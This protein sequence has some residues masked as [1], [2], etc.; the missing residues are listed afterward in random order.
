MS[1]VS[2]LFVE[3]DELVRVGL[4]ML[5][6][7]MTG[8]AQVTLAPGGREALELIPTVHPHVVITDLLMPVFD[9]IA[10]TTI[11]REQHPGIPI[12]ILTAH[13]DEIWLSR[14][15]RA[16]VSGF[17]LK[18]SGVHELEVA[19]GAVTR[20]ERYVTPRMD[21]HIL[22]ERCNGAQSITRRQRETLQ[23]IANGKTNKEIAVSLEIDVKTVEKHRM[24]L[25]HRLGV[26]NTAELVRFALQH[27][28]L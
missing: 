2:V 25:M 17:V 26:R 12:V 6:S 14:A 8:V 23:L 22:I 3:D 7:R 28:L 15:L 13:P 24:D 9:G 4:G 18:S 16:G 5:L 11:I 21:R 10:L 1:L 27:E 20:G 19:L